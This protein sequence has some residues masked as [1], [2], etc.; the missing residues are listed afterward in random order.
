MPKQEETC[1]QANLQVKM[2]MHIL[3]SK[4]KTFIQFLVF[5]RTYLLKI[6]SS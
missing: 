6:V 3:E 4:E 2:T 5:S 1:G